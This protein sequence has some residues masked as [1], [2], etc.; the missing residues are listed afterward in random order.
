M[1]LYRVKDI[2]ANP[3]EKLFDG[4]DITSYDVYV[5]EDGD[6]KKAGN[7][8][9]LLLDESGRFRYF[10]VDTGLWVFGKTV[11]MPVGYA[12]MDY[13]NK[14]IYAARLTKEQVEALPEYDDDMVIDDPYETLVYNSYAGTSVERSAAVEQSV[15][16]DV[17]TTE[18]T[19][20]HQY[21]GTANG[22][23]ANATASVTHS[24]Y[25]QS[26]ETYELPK[27]DDRIRLYEERLVAE[28]HR[29]KTGDVTISKSV[30]TST[31]QVSVPVQKEKIVIEVSQ[32]TT[33]AAAA[34]ATNFKDT[35]VTKMELHQDVAAA[36]KDVQLRET[37]KVRKVVEQDTKTFKEEVRREELDVDSSDS[38]KVE[39]RKL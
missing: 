39:T 18:P 33:R 23:S 36:R 2:Y 28:K 10:A 30:E 16:V 32:P 38:A 14:R 15:P 13:D 8:K 27:E 7:V 37:V 9:N 26:P 24:R 35:E 6:H 4:H 1:A 19:S 22:Q 5:V 3:A 34:G 31:E 29:E 11:L 17:G 12:K 21:S 20:S 25:A